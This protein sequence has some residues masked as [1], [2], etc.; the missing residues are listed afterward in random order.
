MIPPIDKESKE[1][2]YEKLGGGKLFWSIKAMEDTP[3]LKPIWGKTAR[4]LIIA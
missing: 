4:T 3:R 2:E 1:S